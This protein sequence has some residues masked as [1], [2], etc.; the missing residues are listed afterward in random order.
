M[1]ADLESQVHET[2]IDYLC[3]ICTELITEPYLLIEC[4]HHLCQQCRDRLLSI[5]KM[6]CPTCRE[7]DVLTNAVLDKHFQRKVKSL[8]VRCLDYKKGCEW[9][10]ELRD[11]HDHLDPAKGR[12]VIACPFSCLFCCSIFAHNSEM[13]EHS[14]HHCL[15][16]M[17]SC[18][19]CGYYDTFTIVTKKHYP[20]CRLFPIDCPNHCP[21]E[22]LRRYQL[23]EHLKECTQQL[24]NCPKS[25]CS[26]RLP[27]GEMKLHTVQ[28]HD[29]ILE[30]TNQAVITPAT[31]S[32]QYLY[33]QAPMEFIISNFNEK[34][35]ANAKW[36]SSSF[37]TRDKGYRFRLKLY[38]NGSSAV[39]GS[40]VSIFATLLKGKNDD[41]L[42]WPFEGVIMVEILNWKEDKNHYSVAICLDRCKDPDGRHTSHVGSQKA[43][44]GYGIPQFISHTDLAP[45]T[46]TKY[47]LDDYLKLRVSVRY[48][49]RYAVARCSFLAADMRSMSAIWI[50]ASVE[51]NCY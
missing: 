22:S 6:E 46:S 25:G 1:S 17:I 26:V 4:G 30:E 27:R 2:D 50:F 42:E 11:L 14:R 16:R 40:H 12:C 45:T 49:L 41:K 39:R 31:V 33:N 43:A 18:E 47:L 23:Q 35:E 38:P 32:S 3:P 5:G 34:K 21:V 19:N 9:V 7:P 36:F 29:L 20:I 10:G 28:Q 37:Y 8:K 44:P 51:A 15:E 48:E 24:V 13:R